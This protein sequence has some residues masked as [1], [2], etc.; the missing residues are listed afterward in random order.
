M[1]SLLIVRG[2]VQHNFQ[3]GADAQVLAKGMAAVEFPQV[4]P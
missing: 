3:K 2:M 4:V 1:V